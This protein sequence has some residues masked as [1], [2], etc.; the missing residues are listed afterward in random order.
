[1]PISHLG[2][3][4]NNFFYIK[5]KSGIFLEKKSEALCTLLTM[6]KIYHIFNNSIYQYRISLICLSS[7]KTTVQNNDFRCPEFFFLICF[8]FTWIHARNITFEVRQKTQTLSVQNQWSDRRIFLL[9]SIR[10]I[11]FW[12]EGRGWFC[13]LH[14]WTT[15]AIIGRFV[16]VL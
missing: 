6:I 5:K 3:L 1:M 11:F 12:G 13:C 4:F 15:A 10:E 7:K 14:L 16:C 2:F 8:F 9:A